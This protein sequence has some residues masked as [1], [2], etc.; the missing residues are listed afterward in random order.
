MPCPVLANGLLICPV[1]LSFLC[2]RL[3]EISSM[4]AYPDQCIWFAEWQRPTH[5]C[6]RYIF[7][8]IHWLSLVHAGPNGYPVRTMESIRTHSNSLGAHPVVRTQ[9]QCAPWKCLVRRTG[10][11][12]L[13][14]SFS[15]GGRNLCCTLSVYYVAAE[16][17]N[18]YGM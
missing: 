6:Q 4:G 1:F 13:K 3:A 14:Q 5:A 16:F 12:R 15:C 2:I 17:C 8:L 9:W 10:S 11:G 7:G 18:K